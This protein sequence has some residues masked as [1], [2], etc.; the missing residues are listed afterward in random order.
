MNG[1]RITNALTLLLGLACIQTSSP[2]LTPLRYAMAIPVL[3][4]L[5]DGAP[6]VT[7]PRTSAS[8]SSE[9]NDLLAQHAY[10]GKYVF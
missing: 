9:D 8:S 3:C 1:G 2:G 6:L 4:L 7:L 10:L 5:G